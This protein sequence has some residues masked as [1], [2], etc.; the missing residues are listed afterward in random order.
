MFTPVVPVDGLAG[1]RFLQ[2][3][4][5][6]Q[7]AAFNESS[8]LTRATE[9]FEEKISSV[10]S[11]EDLVS[12]RRLREVALGAFGLQDDIDNLFFIGKVLEEG[13]TNDD[14][15]A[16]RFSDNRYKDFSAAF[17][18]GPGEQSKV[19]DPGFAQDIIAKY[20]ANS[21]EVATGTQNDSMRVALFAQREIPVLASQDTSNDAKWFGIMGQPPLRAVFEKAFSL[22]SSFGQIDIDQQLVVFKERSRSVFGTDEVSQFASDETVQDLVTKYIVR[23]QLDNFNAATSSASLALQLLQA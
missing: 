11:A 12:D 5:D 4:Y 1:W 18:L 9:Y 21:F 22:P 17:G 3:T 8:Q 10:T 19:G 13:T 2:R 16:N 20:Q 14:S 7:F 6:S 23:S 15:L